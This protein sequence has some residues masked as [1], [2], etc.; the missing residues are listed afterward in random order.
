MYEIACL[1]VLHQ[2]GPFPPFS[3]LWTGGRLLSCASVEG[4]VCTTV[5]RHF[6]SA[7][8]KE[9]RDVRRRKR[10]AGS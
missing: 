3:L 5:K 6:V 8:Q 4:N 10:C 1:H 9:K 7:F 2:I